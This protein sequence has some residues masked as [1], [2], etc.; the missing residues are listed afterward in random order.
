MSCDLFHVGHLKAI[1]WCSQFGKVTVGLLTDK[2]IEAYKKKPIIPFEH[3]KEIL[4]SIREV[5]RVI[6]QHSLDM[7]LKGYDY[8]ASGDGWE[9]KELKSIEKYGCEK[10]DIQLKGEEEGQKL[11]SSTNIKNKICENYA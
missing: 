4:E 11:H 2:A 6:P 10:L 8:V 5:H 3:R 1:K 7:K 9:K